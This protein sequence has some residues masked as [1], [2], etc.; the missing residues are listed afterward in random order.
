MKNPN[1]IKKIITT[2]TLAALLALSSCSLPEIRTTEDEKIAVAQ[3]IALAQMPVASSSAGTKKEPAIASGPVHIATLEKGEAKGPEF[4]ENAA[5]F[6][7][8][9]IDG[10]RIYGG[11][12]GHYFA[13]TSAT[14]VSVTTIKTEILPDE[15]AITLMESLLLAIE[16]MRYERLYMLLGIN[17]LGSELD[18]FI[19]TYNELLDEIIEAAPEIE[20]YIISITPVTEEKSST[21]ETFSRERVEEYNSALYTLAQMRGLYYADLYT[22]FAGEDGYLPEED[23]TDGV[24]LTAPKYAEWTDYLKEHY[25]VQAE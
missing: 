14:V 12:G 22:V 11:I 13:A 23:S 6:G 5:F 4:F 21:S 7:N 17:E 24:H 20:V 15:E 9:F 25:A 19:S 2:G 10:L 18:S 1:H 16:E 3:E 8:S